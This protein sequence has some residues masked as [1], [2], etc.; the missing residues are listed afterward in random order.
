MQK[1]HIHIPQQACYIDIAQFTVADKG[2]EESNAHSL[3]H[4]NV[5]AVSGFADPV[6]SFH[7]DSGTVKKRRGALCLESSPEIWDHVQVELPKLQAAI[8]IAC[9]LGF[10]KRLPN[11]NEGEPSFPQ[12]APPLQRL[13]TAPCRE[14]RAHTWAAE[15]ACMQ[16]YTAACC[17]RVPS[18]F[19]CSDAIPFALRDQH[20]QVC[21]DEHGAHKRHSPQPCHHVA[22][23][24]WCLAIVTHQVEA[25]MRPP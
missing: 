19:S 11:P 5:A 13:T 10:A 4:H 14:A 15:R 12:T 1:G 18:S 21:P 20:D 25:Q 23:F 17:V 3:H 7:L 24:A 9:R 2:K 8:S 22:Y 6:S 16:C